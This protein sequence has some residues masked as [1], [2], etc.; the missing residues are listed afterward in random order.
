MN[1]D[2]SLTFRFGHPVEQVWQALTDAELLEKWIWDNDF[3]PIQTREFQFRAEPNEWWDGIVNGKV[4]KVEEPRVLS[5]TWD[6]AGEQTTVQWVLEKETEGTTR[7][8]FEQGGFS[9]ETKSSEEAMQGA[10]HAWREMAYQLG[11]VLDEMKE[12]NF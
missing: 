3:K 10:E 11:N 5:Y 12:S 7:L 9:E 1:A 8:L 2:V 4:L 6:S